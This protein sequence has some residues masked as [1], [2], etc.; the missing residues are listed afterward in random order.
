M[1]IDD[2]AVRDLLAEA[3]HRLNSESESEEKEEQQNGLDMTFAAEIGDE[4]DN[5][6]QEQVETV[7]DE[8]EGKPESSASPSVSKDGEAAD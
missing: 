3:K 8:S 2:F 6:N 7:S 1:D 4:E 5:A